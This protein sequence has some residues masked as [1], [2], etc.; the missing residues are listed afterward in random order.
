VRRLDLT[1]RSADLGLR[2]AFL[3]M[4]SDD[5]TPRN[6][7]LTMRSDDLTMRDDFVTMRN[8]LLRMRSVG[9]RFHV[10][11][12]VLPG[13]PLGVTVHVADAKLARAL[14]AAMKKDVAL[15]VRLRVVGK[16]DARPMSLFASTRRRAWGFVV[17]SIVR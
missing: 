10:V 3:T 8:A 6:H 13:E 15:V 12:E 1:M 17:E 9:V 4:R 11:K 16:N 2:N 14:R 7:L 5:L